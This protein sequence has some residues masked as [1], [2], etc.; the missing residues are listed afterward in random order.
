MSFLKLSD[1]EQEALLQR[2]ERGRYFLAFV[3]YEEWGV[4]RAVRLISHARS[5]SSYRYTCISPEDG[6]GDDAEYKAPYHHEYCQPYRSS[7][8]HEPV[9]GMVVDNCYIYAIVE[10]EE[11][12][13][14]LA[15]A[16]HALC[17][18]YKTEIAGPLLKFEMGL[19]M[20]MD[21]AV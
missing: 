17:Q 15:E 8:S 9:G 13:N 12:A 7:Q 1:D 14:A 18:V 2:L 21:Q 11:E 6:D 3:N 5:L 10:T 16:V 4:Y 19:R 20:V